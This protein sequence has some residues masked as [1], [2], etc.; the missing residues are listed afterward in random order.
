VV[1]CEPGALNEGVLITARQRRA[2]YFLTI[3]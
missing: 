3:I 1:R 2:R